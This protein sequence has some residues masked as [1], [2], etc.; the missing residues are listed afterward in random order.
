MEA[1]LQ[2]LLVCIIPGSFIALLANFPKLIKWMERHKVREHPTHPPIERL[3]ADLRR[4]SA[5]QDRVRGGIVPARQRR[6]L[7]I[8]LAY[9]DVL[10][11]CCDVLE[12]PHHGPPP[13]TREQRRGAEAAL[14]RAGL[15]W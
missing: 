4:L 9:D 1:L 8:E 5:E 15:R 7:A 14:L 10:L 12:L 2:Y 6:L 13:L 3:V 11:E